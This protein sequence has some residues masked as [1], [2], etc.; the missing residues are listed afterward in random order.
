MDEKQKQRVMAAVLVFNLIL[1]FYQIFFNGFLFGEFT[2]V[3]LLIGL[4][5]S[6]AGA[7]ATY[8]AVQFAQK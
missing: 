7:G 4:L 8:L 2:I 3:K 5:L 6:A 1:I